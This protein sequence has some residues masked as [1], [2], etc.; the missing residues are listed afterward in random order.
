LTPAFFTK[1]DVSD[2]RISTESNDDLF[3]FSL[4]PSNSIIPMFIYRIQYSCINYNCTT[5][6]RAIL[7]HSR[8]YPAHENAF[9]NAFAWA[10]QNVGQ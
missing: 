2:F 8:A 10:S 1:I 9:E 5:T 7:Q 6:S 4:F 3:I